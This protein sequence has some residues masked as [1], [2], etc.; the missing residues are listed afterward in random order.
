MLDMNLI[1][2]LAVRDGLLEEAYEPQEE[3]EVEKT[4]IPRELYKQLRDDVQYAV[5]KQFALEEINPKSARDPVIKSK[6]SNIVHYQIKN[7]KIDVPEPEVPLLAEQLFSDILGYGPLEK[8]F[9]DEEVSEIMVTGCLIYIEK[10]GH[11]FE[12]P[13]RFETVE[14]GKDLLR[15]MLAKTGERIDQAKPEVDA[16]LH[17][18]SRL[19]AQIAP[20][21]ENELLIT[22]RRFRQDIDIETLIQNGAASKKV[23]E[24]LEKAI[25]MR[26]N[27]MIAG[28][29]SSGKTTWLNNLAS[30]IDPDLWVITIENP[31]E[32]DLK[33]PKVRSLVA[34]KANIENK[35]EYTMSDAVKSALRMNPDIIV[36]GEIRR[37]ESLDLL[38][39]MGTGHEGSLGT[40]HANSAEDL[41]NYRFPDMIRYAKEAQ[42]LGND[43][44]LE[45]IANPLD[46]V[47][48]VTNDRG[49]RRLD[50]I[51][52]VAGTIKNAAGKTMAVKTN[53]LWEYN[54]K[55]G[56]W[57]WVAQE[58]QREKRFEEVGWYCPN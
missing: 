8:Y 47:L 17:D 58:F 3:Q 52:E 1:R 35:G 57:D 44:I 6:F 26:M 41:L 30:F 7:L 13:E 15:R 53:R 12:A 22:I 56:D 25:K 19:N 20:I 4:L 55:T 31:A 11:N 27:L 48:F 36:V 2:V 40:A 34:R 39:A 23:I 43:T 21:T 9:N 38:Q 37:E 54:N 18:G 42:Q 10:K 33:H 5:R 51:V 28:G 14:Q 49:Y 50:H 46:I 16:R 29:T 32:L 45:K 24:F